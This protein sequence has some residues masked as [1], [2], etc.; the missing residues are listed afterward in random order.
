MNDTPVAIAIEED[1]PATFRDLLPVAGALLAGQAV[2]VV[3]LIVLCRA[4]ARTK[5]RKDNILSFR[6]EK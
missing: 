1:A 2:L 6:N 3:L 4:L 5:V